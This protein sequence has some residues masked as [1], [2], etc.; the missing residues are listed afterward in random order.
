M[1][2]VSES[3]S[4]RN[5][6][7][8]VGRFTDM[9]NVS[10]ANGRTRSQ[11]GYRTRDLSQAE[12]LGIR[13]A[14]WSGNVKS[15]IS[16]YE[17]AG[18]REFGKPDRA[19]VVHDR[20]YSEWSYHHSEH[21]VSVRMGNS[22]PSSNERWF[23]HGMI[24]LTGVQSGLTPPWPSKSVT[25]SVAGSLLRRS[26][27]AQAEINLTRSLGEL[28]DFPSMLRAT[29]VPK[30]S[31]IK[32]GAEAYLNM[33]FGLQPTLSD[34]QTLAETVIKA[35]PILSDYV[36]QEK[37]RMRRRATHTFGSYA[38]SGVF[39]GGASYDSITPV[40]FGP[41]QAQISYLT[42][43]LPDSFSD[44]LSAQVAWSVTAS[45]KLVT[46]ATYEYYIPSPEGVHG[47][48]REYSQLAER[49]IGGGLN[50][51]TIYDLTPYSWLL[52]WFTD[53]GGLISYQQNVVDNQLVAI[54]KSFS[55]IETIHASA[56]LSSVRYNPGNLVGAWTLKSPLTVST[57]GP[58][59]I[60]WK[61]LQRRAGN[62]FSI[63]PAWTG[64]SRQQWAILAAMG[65]SR[66]EGVPTIRGG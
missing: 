49:L 16:F 56:V 41:I 60:R 34:L 45:Q 26:A 55:V 19:Y 6:T 59:T 23:S 35:G 32:G 1:P 22:N 44:V 53:V 21:D 13:D 15:L 52:D 18:S 63:T 46:S 11:I 4:D 28:K 65:L 54:R 47:R 43:G 17:E 10:V 66:G 2:I 20:D 50:A 38:N 62:P 7:V 57:G 64:L 48:L 42:P 51:S 39:T 27:P 36:A 25:E 5:V 61:K 14:S 33:V 24:S 30:F 31:S 37:V 58:A 8:K 40:S 12:E 29:K 9:Q 3:S